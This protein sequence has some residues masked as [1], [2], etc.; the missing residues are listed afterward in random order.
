VI[1]SGDA[2]DHME[3][4]VSY[5]QVRSNNPFGV[6]LQ[7]R[8]AKWL[9]FTHFID[10]NSSWQQEIRSFIWIF[11]QDLLPSLSDHCVNAIL[12]GRGAHSLST[13]AEPRRH[14]WRRRRR[15]SYSPHLRIETQ[16]CLSAELDCLTVLIPMFV[17]G[18]SPWPTLSMQMIFLQS[19]KIHH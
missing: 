13:S 10:C 14:P 11:I 16:L 4:W 5:S 18:G 2:K 9:E 17:V 1:K 6:C 7:V 19:S 8:S 12:L 3:S 15:R